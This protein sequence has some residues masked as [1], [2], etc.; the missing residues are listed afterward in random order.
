MNLDLNSMRNITFSIKTEDYDTDG[1]KV[2]ELYKVS[3]DKDVKRLLRECLQAT[4]TEFP[5]PIDSTLEFEISEKYGEK[6]RFK[7]NVS[8]Y[9]LVGAIFDETPKDNIFLADIPKE[10]IQYY[11][12]DFTDTHGNQASCI[13]RASYFKSLLKNKNRIV[14]F[15][16][17][18]IEVV[19]DEFFKLDNDFDFICI[20]GV[21]YILR[22]RVFESMVLPD[23][24][25]TRKA[26]EKISSLS[27]SL[28]F[29]NFDT[30][31][32]V[33]TKYKRAARLVFA[34]SQREDIHDIEKSKIIYYAGSSNIE[35]EVDDDEVIRPKEGFE[36]D[37]LEMLDRRIYNVE[38]ID[39]ETE[40][41]KAYSRK[42][43]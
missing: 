27:D 24:E 34:V 20:N 16:D 10:K 23:E 9:P 7:V 3:T 35:I 36:V 8:E 30:I 13:R 43:R 39:G 6:D 40:S 28:A 29:V 33:V 22:P 31:Y 18:S 21:A 42:R 12:V 38:F 17:D 25:V 4:L 5:D 26:L 1:K 2:E 41:Y 15:I 19:N 11:R 37:F 32:D 14:R